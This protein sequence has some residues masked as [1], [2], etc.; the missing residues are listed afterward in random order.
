MLKLLL[1]FLI[2]I[3]FFALIILFLPILVI[4]GKIMQFLG[5]KN[6]NLNTTRPADTKI[7]SNDVIDVDAVIIDEKTDKE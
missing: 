4:T 1:I 2:F 5:Y 7:K 6:D 3:I